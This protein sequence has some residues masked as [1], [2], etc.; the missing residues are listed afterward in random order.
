MST[1]EKMPGHTRLYRRNATYYH[2][3]AVPEDI[4]GTYGKRE[5]TFSLKTKDYARACELVRRKAVEVDQRFNAHRQRLH[6]EQQAADRLGQESLDALTPEQSEAI[7]QAY[8]AHL[9]E[10]DEAA[11]LDTFLKD[12]QRDGHAD[13]PE[14]PRNTLKEH[15]ENAASA[16][17]GV[18]LLYATG[19]NN[20]AL[21]AEVAE[22]LT[23]SPVNLNVAEGSQ[24]WREAVRALQVAS[25]RAY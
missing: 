19:E 18:K 15:G 9:L 2:R 13:L 20:V 14:V 11:R 16:L 25:R 1:L 24:G 22:V 21:D 3:C 4:R 10:E 17:A 8:Y 6:R 12:T 23:W 7:E 5:E